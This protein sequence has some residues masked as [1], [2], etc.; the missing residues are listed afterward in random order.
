M[1]V[2][3][4]R[5]KLSLLRSPGS[6]RFQKYMIHTVVH[7][8][9]FILKRL[10]GFQNHSINISVNIFFLIISYLIFLGLV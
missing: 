5:H 8:S 9:K 6:K 3:R 7:Y 10:N 2:N 1:S 4:E